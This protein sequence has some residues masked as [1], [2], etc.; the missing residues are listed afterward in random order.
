MLVR[1][2]HA[3][4][5]ASNEVA[6]RETTTMPGLSNSDQSS[7]RPWQELWPHEH[8]TDFCEPCKS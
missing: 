1:D 2:A 6:V 3:S 8:G 4:W 7:L 5:G